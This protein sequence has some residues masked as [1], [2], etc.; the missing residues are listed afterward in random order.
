MAWGEGQCRVIIAKGRYS[1][2]ESAVADDIGR[3]GES[4]FDYQMSQTD[5][6]VGKI[7]PDRMGKDRVI[8][9]KLAPRNAVSFDKRSAPMACSI[10]IKTILPKTKG[11]K[12]SLS[13]AERLAQG[14]APA[15]VY[16]IRLDDNRKPILGPALGKIL[17]RLRKEFSEGTTEY[18]DKSIT[19]SI[20]EAKTIGPLG[21]DLA[22]YLER[23]IGSDMEEYAKRKGAQKRDLGYE[24]G[25]RTKVTG[26]FQAAAI[27]DFID[28]LLGLKPLAIGHIKAENQ[29][30][31]IGTHETETTE[32]DGTSEDA[33]VDE[34]QLA[35]G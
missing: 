3:I 26:S 1:M 31:G 17:K 11:V 10:Q 35:E 22:K 12:V 8:E 14:L 5:L 4:Y 30:F 6:L 9:A 33:A 20:K 25:Q 21:D 29:R 28:G 16:I 7:D 13:V 32:I 15:F 2:S 23:E 34:P 24:N 18:K 19:F 27:N